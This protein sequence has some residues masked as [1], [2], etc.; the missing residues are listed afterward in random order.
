MDI[1][2]KRLVL[3]L[4]VVVYTMYCPVTEASVVNTASTVRVWPWQD[5]QLPCHFEDE[6]FAV[7]W[8]RESTSHQQLDMIKASFFGG[9]FASKEERFNI[10]KN[11]SLV[12]NDLQV[13]DGGRYHCQLVLETFEVFLNSTLLTVRSPTVDTAPTVHGWKGE[14]IR[15]P[16]DFKEEPLA[17]YWVKESMLQP[18]LSTSK[19]FYDGNFVSMEARFDIDRNFGL[20]ITDLKVADEGLYYCQLVLLDFEVFENSTL[21]TVSSVASKHAI[22]ECVDDS[23]PNPSRCTYHTPSETSSFDLT[24]VVSGFKPNVTMLWT[25]ESGRTLYSMISKQTTLSDDT[26]ERF[27]IINV[28]ARHGT[29]Q[30]FKCTATGD[31]LDGT[32][33][34]EITVL[35]KPVPGKR[36]N[37]ALIVGPVIGVLVALAIIV[38]L[39]GRRFLRKA[40][41]YLQKERD[42]LRRKIT[43]YVPGKAGNY[44]IA[45]PPSKVNIIFF[46]EIA[47]GKSCL[48][49]SLNFALNGKGDDFY[50]YLF[51]LFFWGGG[52]N[53]P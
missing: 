39:L 15:L 37:V 48:I 22:E 27:E 49:N 2:Y 24:C 28:S 12:I 1:E 25:E 23:Q 3:P 26:Y 38:V 41:S 33:T 6:P 13:A 32:S 52:V 42:E 17:V 18:E 44:Y 4:I 14:D 30:T 46:G 47:A 10:N 9:N 40:D 51:I 29:E 7:S 45:N 36:S 43:D 35:P 53:T 16:C 50:F 31:S 21:M 34:A 8:V 19:A 11:F 20:L 5:I